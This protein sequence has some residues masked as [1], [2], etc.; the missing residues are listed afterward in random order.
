GST[1][2]VYTN[3][4]RHASHQPGAMRR[5]SPRHLEHPGQVQQRPLAGGRL[6]GR[7]RRALRHPAVALRQPAAGR[8]LAL[9]AR[10]HR[11]ATA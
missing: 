3:K 9:A 2:L 1:I 5:R 7:C 11:P 6:H 8:S 10:R 4:A